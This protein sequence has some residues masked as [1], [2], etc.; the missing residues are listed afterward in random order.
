[1]C[2]HSKY[3]LEVTHTLELTC[4]DLA[5]EI[6]VTRLLRVLGQLPCLHRRSKVNKLQTTG[7][8]HGLFLCMHLGSIL[9]KGLV[10]GLF[11]TGPSME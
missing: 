2:T 7:P 3:T 9:K 8:Q 11:I 6:I 4:Y 5:R 10:H 1:M